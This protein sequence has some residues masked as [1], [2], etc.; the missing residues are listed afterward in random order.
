[1]SH[2]YPYYRPPDM[3]ILDLEPVR[4]TAPL[5]DQQLARAL[6]HASIEDR[7]YHWCFRMT[8]DEWAET[9]LREDKE[10]AQACRKDRLDR[11]KKQALAQHKAVQRHRQ[12]QQPQQSQHM[13]EPR[14]RHSADEAQSQPQLRRL[15]QHMQHKQQQQQQS[16]PRLLRP[17]IVPQHFARQRQRQG[18]GKGKVQQTMFHKWSGQR[19]PH[20]EGLRHRG[21]GAPIMQGNH[22]AASPLRPEHHSSEYTAKGNHMAASPMMH[23][24]HYGEYTAKG[25]HM[26]ASPMM[27]EPLR[28]TSM[29]K[30]MGKGDPMASMWMHGKAGDLRKG[31]PMVASMWMHGKASGVGKG[32]PMAASMWMHG[33]AGLGKG[34]PM[35]TMMTMTD[36]YIGGMQGAHMAAPMLVQHPLRGHGDMQGNHMAASQTVPEYHDSEYMQG[37]HMAAS[38]MLPEHL[39]GEYMQGN[40]MAASPVLA[41]AFRG[42]YTQGKHMAA[43]QP[44]FHA[45]MPLPLM[46]QWQHQQQPQQQQPGGFLRLHI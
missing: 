7:R 6:E 29:G 25:N 28:G 18:K 39:R 43:S 26:A 27:H 35:A 5:T 9:F 23:E 31:D 4:Q 15:H 41:A 13:E 17:R 45:G 2:S 38:L 32:D 1:M 30:G 10:W 40:H 46:E 14:R 12:A 33:K 8:L 11:F 22:M 3:T 19:L 44:V 37:N 21:K 34:D 20:G 36:P 42:E 16:F 24:E